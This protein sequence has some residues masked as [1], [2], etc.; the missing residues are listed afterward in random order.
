MRPNLIQAPTGADSCTFFAIYDDISSGKR[1]K[2]TCD[3]I[4]GKFGPECNVHGDF[5]KL[6][7]LREPT[8][9][10]LA[11]PL[12]READI[13]IF[14]TNIDKNLPLEIKTWLEDCLSNETDRLRVLMSVSCRLSSASP[15]PLL[16]ETHLQEIAARKNVEFLSR[17]IETEMGRAAF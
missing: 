11:A 4:R 3:Y 7:V 9:M 15:N 12:A 14:S 6:D 1:A 16:I 10:H 8:L 17:V 2:E 5:W 13:I